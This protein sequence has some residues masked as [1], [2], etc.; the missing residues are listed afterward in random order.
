LPWLLDHLLGL[1]DKI[2]AIKVTGP[3]LQDSQAVLHMKEAEAMTQAATPSPDS[4][5][6]VFAKG[7]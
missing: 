6:L 2:T 4:E 1:A 7:D 5:R 3:Q